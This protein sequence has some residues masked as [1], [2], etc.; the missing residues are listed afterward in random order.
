MP[1]SACGVTFEDVLAAAER[2][3]GVAHR[4][5]VVTSRTLDARTGARA[6]LKCENLQRM[7]AF[8]FRG[9]FNRIAQLSA[10]ERARGVVAFSS[11]NH[12]QG[13]ALAARLLDVAATIVMPSDAPRSKVAATRDYGA[14]VVLYDR[15]TMNRGAIAAEIAAERGATIVPP[16]DDPAIIAGQGTAVLELLEDVPDIDVL[17]VCTGGG[18]LL[19]GSAVAAVAKRPHVEI[20]GVEPEAGDDFAQSFVR[21]ERVE[22]A[23]PDTIADGQMTTSPGELTFPIVK[24]LCAGILTVSDDDLRAAMR[25]AFERL[26]LVLEPS[27]A[28]ALAALLAGAIVAPGRR[29]GITLSGGNI[30]A[31][32]Y[33]EILATP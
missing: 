6:F 23:V 33:A 1:E 16:Y 13:V 10:T 32:R 24:R 2:L 12:A 30:D 7:G 20:Y 29:V 14:Q 21:G 8:K 4:T 28:A 5:P 31:A 22:I 15:H 17:L 3:R 25:F 27:G 11:G 18:G 9:A 26:K 19:A